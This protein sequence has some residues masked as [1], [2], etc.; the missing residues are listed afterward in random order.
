MTTCRIQPILISRFIVNLFRAGKTTDPQSAD[1]DSVMLSTVVGPQRPATTIEA[2]VGPVGD[3]LTYGEDDDDEPDNI[4]DS[5]T[6]NT[7]HG[8]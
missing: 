5:V 8:L 3:Y 7:Y 6:A 2:I 1:A 4:D